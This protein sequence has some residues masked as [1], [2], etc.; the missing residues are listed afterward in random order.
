MRKLFKGKSE[1]TLTSTEGLILHHLM[2]NP[3]K[4]ITISMLSDVVWGG[5]Y[6]NAAEA[7]RVYIRR[8]RE[9]IETD[10][11]HPQIIHTEA[12]LGYTLKKAG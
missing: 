12:G 8:L 10:P 9:K 3:N 4:V 6:P 11:S 1:I 7:I 2:R 5:D